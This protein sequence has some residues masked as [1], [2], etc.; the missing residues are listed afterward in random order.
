MVYM[1]QGKSPHPGQQWPMS[2]LKQSATLT[3]LPKSLLQ[4]NAYFLEASRKTVL[5][6]LGSYLRH[7]LLTLIW[8]ESIP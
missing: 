2:D 5:F 6:L 7:S 1:L 4:E 3:C 8:A